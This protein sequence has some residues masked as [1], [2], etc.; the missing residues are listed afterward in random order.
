MSL[1]VVVAAVRVNAVGTGLSDGAAVALDV[2]AIVG[3]GLLYAAVARPRTA[4]PLQTLAV[5]LAVSLAVLGFTIAVAVTH[6]GTIDPKTA[7]PADTETGLWGAGIGLAELGLSIIVLTSLRPLVLHRRRQATSR[8]WVVLLG[9]LVVAALMVVGRPLTEPMPVWVTIPIAAS[10]L[11]GSSLALRQGW[12]EELT[13]GLRLIAAALAL[14]LAATLVTLLAVQ[15]MGSAMIPVGNGTGAV[16]AVPYATS[17]SRPLATLVIMAL[18]FGALYTFTAGLV[19]LFGLPSAD[20]QDQRTGE[21]RALR[22]LSDLSGRVLDREAL[23]SAVAQGPVEAG[24]ADAAWVALTDPAHGSITPR[25][26]AAS[27]IDLEAAANAVDVD[28][29]YRA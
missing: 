16:E 2:I 7:L 24:L 28:A 25:V 4:G 8:T 20:L 12:V 9:L 29:L 26:Q 23:A 6:D 22:S 14:V 17:M 21:R 27:G 13:S 10:L 18:S 19:L 3:T 11:L 15:T 1:A 5:P